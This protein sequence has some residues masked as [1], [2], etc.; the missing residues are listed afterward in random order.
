MKKFL[1]LATL[2]MAAMQ[3]SA[4]NVDLATARATAHH[5]MVSDA[6][7]KQLRAIPMSNLKL[8]KAEPN[9]KR[10]DLSVY[11][12]FDTE[13]GF[14]IV[15]G[16]DR[17]QQILAFGD[18]PLRDINEIPDNMKFW[19][20]TYKRQIEFLQENPNI[21]V[22]NHSTWSK[23][24]K[25]PTV[26]PLLTALWDQDAPYYNQCPKYNGSYCLTGCPATSLSMVFYY[27][28]YPTDPTPE[29]EGYT[30]SSY[31]FEVPA[32]PSITFDWDNMLDSYSGSYTTAQA[33]AVAWLMRYVGQEEH[34][35][36]TPSGSGAYGDD[37]LRAVKFFGYDENTAELVFKSVADD[38]ANE[39]ELINDE[40][41]AAM[42]QNE[43]A[44]GRPVVYCAYDYSYWYGWSGHAFN[45]DGYKASDNTYHV[46]W[47]WSGSGN[48]YFA[49]NAFSSSGY[50]FNI[51][52]Q[53]VMG[54]QPPVSGPAVK[55]NPSKL[56]MEAYVDQSA[57]AT[58]TVKGQE[59]SSAITLTL[60]D[61]TGYFSIDANSVALS[62]QEDGKV[63]N[64]TYSPLASGVHTATIT[65]SS[66]G[67]DDKV[68]TVN[69]TSVIEAFTPVM[70]PTDSAYVNL[71]QF[72]AD[73]TDQTADKYVE[74]YTLNVNTKPSVTLLEV[75]DFSDYPVVNGNQASNAQNYLPEGWVFDG[76]GFW[77][78][79]AS[80]EPS[81]GSTVTSPR[82][83]LSGYE[84]VTV[85]V[86]YKSW[87]SYTMATLDVSTSVDSKSFTGTTSFTEYTAVLN[88]SESENIVFTAG[89]YPMIQKIQI[90]AGELDE[91]TLRA[92][93]EDD[94]NNPTSRLITGITNKNYTVKNLEAGGTFYYK[95]K[96][97]YTDGTE[98]PWSNSKTITLFENGHG[99]DLGD[100][101]HDEEVG[102]A[103]VTDL[104]NYLLT[105]EGNI[106]QICADMD[107][108]EE[109]SIADVTALIRYLLTGE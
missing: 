28:K 42:L 45:V 68:V 3:V 34:M 24:F 72:R 61:E 69:G 32:L 103:D 25:T 105:G 36:Y 104:I 95:V 64:V 66:P 98:S 102:I 11:Y 106:C 85:L 58:F 101:N 15:A 59:L 30:N 33:N 51:E 62:E 9:S 17:A 10:S 94:P 81:S 2:L 4:A 100:V 41:W 13:Q 60:N 77:L 55:V 43:L 89:Y 21:V 86:T 22:D 27:W 108:D 96:A 5:F 82:Y 92:I 1:F 38:N 93:I 6:N 80:I 37:I 76:A 52:Q 79:G 63:I 29:V 40:D 78:D 26:E 35:D 48:G 12:V 47:G 57:T 84:K 20:S 67:V 50:T 87:S 8:L 56:N 19:L 44:E 109:I 31:G 14:I 49:L 97:I 23:S 83:D 46:N 39:T 16:E 75:A 107:G 65:L 88:C 53:M 74:S 71:T 7:S 99:Y 91:A 18:R 54:I 90:F 70:L 73:W